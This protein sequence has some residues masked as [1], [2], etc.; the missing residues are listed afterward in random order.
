MDKFFPIAPMDRTSKIMSNPFTTIIAI[1][2][3]GLIWLIPYI[4]SPRGYKVTPK[5]II[6]QLKLSS[7]FISKDKIKSIKLVGSIEPGNGI[8][9]LSGQFGYAGLFALKS[10]SMARVYATCWDNMVQIQTDNID[11]YLLSPQDPVNFVKSVKELDRL[12][13]GSR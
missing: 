8:T 5:G 1:C 9:W 13:S 7:H 4:F 10:G 2:S 12:K 3:I 11:P 6:I